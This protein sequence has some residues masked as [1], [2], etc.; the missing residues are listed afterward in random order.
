MLVWWI[1]FTYNLQ[2]LGQFSLYVDFNVYSKLNPFYTLPPK[3]D[4]ADGSKGWY[5]GW[6]NFLRVPNLIIALLDMFLL[7]YVLSIISDHMKST[8]VPI[9]K[10]A[11]L[12]I[13][14]LHIISGPLRT[15]VCKPNPCH[16]FTVAKMPVRSIH[17]LA[18]DISECTSSYRLTFGT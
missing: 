12:S 11:W 14:I 16:S 17:R 7:A 9:V 10:D 3:V 5:L 4:V 6:S 8:G 2:F 18:C 1:A 15:P 13:Q